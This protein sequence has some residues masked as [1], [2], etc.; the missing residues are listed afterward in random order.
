MAYA[1]VN[2]VDVVRG[3]KKKVRNFHKAGDT[4]YHVHVEELGGHIGDVWFARHEGPRG[5]IWTGAAADAEQRY[6]DD[7]VA[8][9]ISLAE[10]AHGPVLPPDYDPDR[11]MT[12][13]QGRK[14]FPYRGGA[15]PSGTPMTVDDT[16]VV[17]ISAE[18][19]RKVLRE[20]TDRQGQPEFR[21]ALIAAYGGQCA[22]TGTD[23]AE[24]LQACHIDPFS[25]D[26]THDLWN[27]LLLR[28]DIHN[29]FDIGQLC[30][31]D[32]YTVRIDDALR[33]GTYGVYHGRMLRLPLDSGHRPSRGALARHRARGRLR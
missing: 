21:A 24:V 10:Q 3:V 15:Q 11:R 7:A 27:G 28:A 25:A 32:D 26:G 1:F 5:W 4:R 29:L 6:I 17:P 22:V 2:G 16:L 9:L 14:V 23:V 19:K 31:D 30:I 18:D 13:E 8:D 33:S 20:V 12:P